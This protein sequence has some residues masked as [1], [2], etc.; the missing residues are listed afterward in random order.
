MLARLLLAFV[1]LVAIGAGALAWRLSQGPIALPWLAH[2]LEAAANA[3]KQP[4]H[5]RD[6]PRGAG[7]GGILAGRRRAARP[8]A[9]PRHRNRC[10]GRADRA[11]AERRTGGGGGAA[12]ARAD[13]ADRAGGGRGAA[14][15][16]PR[17]GWRDRVFGG[18]DGA[19]TAPGRPGALLSEL[20]G[21]HKTVASGRLHL[22]AWRRVLI[23]DA[24]VTVLDRQIG[25]TWSAEHVTIDLRRAAAGGVTGQANA[26]LALGET[27]ARLAA[28][29]AVTPDGSTVTARFSPVTPAALA[30]AA[31]G[32]GALAAL[33]A[34]VSGSTT[35][36]LDRSLGVRHFRLALQ[37]GA[38]QA[39]VAK[40]SVPLVAV[41]LV[42]EGT[43][44][45]ATLRAPAGD[46]RRPVRGQR[47]D[48][49]CQ[50]H[51]QPGRRGG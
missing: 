25:A 36:D 33:D 17:R 21:P 37:V 16:D 4:V 41:D 15:A 42:A 6:R 31:P 19:P 18:L 46:A 32:L 9:R 12:A 23:R 10:R 50:R 13:Y 28:Q 34:P 24:Q 35:L 38:G 7:L 29:A 3:G 11:R 48:L 44:H 40:G 27:S 1:V 49:A 8:S 43:P 14:E 45:A 5:L 22:D 39:Q 2:R 26:T 30:R 47:P 51:P 20:A